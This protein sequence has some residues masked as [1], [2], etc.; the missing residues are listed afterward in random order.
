MFWFVEQLYI[1]EC[2]ARSARISNRAITSLV[3]RSLPRAVVFWTCARSKMPE[4]ASQA[5]KVGEPSAKSLEPFFRMKIGILA[6][7]V[8]IEN[9]RSKRCFR[10]VSKTLT[11]VRTEILKC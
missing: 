11:G 8:I 7:Q 1:H 4:I 6:L 10:V 3:A 5:A 9:T 2:N